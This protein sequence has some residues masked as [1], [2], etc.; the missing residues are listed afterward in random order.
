MG[1]LKGPLTDIRFIGI[2]GVWNSLR[3][4][5]VRDW[6]EWRFHTPEPSGGWPDP[7][8]LQE[9]KPFDGGAVWRFAR[10][11]LEITFLAPDLVRCEWAGGPPPLPYALARTEWPSVN[12]KL[13]QTPDGWLLYT[14]E[15][16]VL[17]RPNGSL[18]FSDAVGRVLREEQ[19]PACEGDGWVHRATLRPEERLYGL[20][21]RAASLNLRGGAYRMW[22]SDPGGSYQR[23]DDPLYV[24]IPVYLG[25]HHDGGY[26][27]FYE[28]PFD[29]TFDL[30]AADSSVAEARFTGG[31]LRMYFVAGPPSRALGRYTQLTGRPPLPPQWALGYHQSR[32]GY[33]S[34]EDVEAVADGFRQ[35]DL[36]LQAIH[37]DIDYMDGFRLFTVDRK[38]FPDLV[39]LAEDLAA[40]GIR[41]V[42]ILDTGVKWDP[43]Y[44]VSREGLAGR[45]FCTK[46]DG[47]PMRA[48]VWPGT[49]VFP[50][51]TSVE[52]RAW[53]GEYYA[54]L[55]DSGIAGFWH[56]MN[57]PAA[58]SKW[59]D[60]TL[61]RVTR[62]DLEGRGGDHREAHNLYALLEARAA[63]ESLRAQRP[64]RRPFI[65]SRAGW[66]GLQRYSWN[67]TGD[68]AST[69]ENLRQT[70]PSVLGLGLSGA[71]NTGPDIG[72]F[73]GA[74][75]AEL[76]LR[77]FQMAAFLPFFRTHSA[78]D[79][80]RREPWEFGEPYLSNVRELLRLRE[81]LLPYL[82]TLCWQA[83]QTGAPM[84]RPLFWSDTS[85]ESLWD[86]DD[87]FLL[88][89]DLLVAP[90]LEPGATAREIVLPGRYWY[91]FWDDECL[92]GWGRVECSA[93]L[94]RIPL[95]ARAGS[96]IPLAEGERLVLHVYAPL[97][98]AG[99]GQLYSDAGD[100]YGPWRL[101]R[102]AMQHGADGLAVEWQTEGDFPMP[103]AA[104]EVSLHGTTAQQVFVDGR[105]LTEPRQQ[106][107]V[108]MFRQLRIEVED[109]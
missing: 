40:Q 34:A 66:A 75:S 101:D 104:V 24:C 63:Y 70:V 77:W 43:D 80:P 99:C 57:E 46:P 4:A 90:A 54:R 94:E 69:W 85:D 14:H 84:V 25:L 78:Q 82:Y 42:T 67:W 87:A 79:T 44:D 88:G 10:T 45:H 49:C 68:T 23:G 61:P 59:G 38:R 1:F 32:W 72:G 2:S 109:N 55:L 39:G 35:H 15:L 53:W 76:Y 58:F 95:L 22:N 41:L 98:G 71:I 31:A 26:L 96:I 19:P 106:F 47:K 51:F 12:T 102:F 107:A 60:R 17:V 93:P 5:L 48:P 30:G 83:Y 89:D 29:A 8:S 105:Q 27:V 86:V 103:Y 81:R 3:Y 74:P 92:Q 37:L 73:S 65:F 97:S 56:D 6:L 18:S 100:G 13:E 62:H 64:E 28:N 21:E 108:G 20:G 9:V 16:V 50:D 91:S 36:P 33:G 7:G 52:T 11:E